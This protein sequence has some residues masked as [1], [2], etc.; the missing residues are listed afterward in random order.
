MAMLKQDL[1]RVLAGEKAAAIPEV[2]KTTASYLKVPKPKSKRAALLVGMAVA[3]LL[4]VLPLIYG[5]VNKPDQT[6]DIASDFRRHRNKAISANEMK[7]YVEAEREYLI[8]LQLAQ[9]AGDQEG[10]ARCYHGLYRSNYRRWVQTERDLS[11]TALWETATKHIKSAVATL[12]PMVLPDLKAR[13]FSNAKFRSNLSLLMVCYVDGFVIAQ[14]SGNDAEALR[15]GRKFVD[16][17]SQY[18]NFYSDR[19]R[20][21]GLHARVLDFIIR[22]DAELGQREDGLKYLRMYEQDVKN[23]LIG[24]AEQIPEYKALL[25]AS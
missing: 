10:I 24:G 15:M 8:A 2:Q 5:L 12:E 14:E 21:T 1:Q 13:N 16:L 11:K 20:G 22:K 4:C 18:S 23:G 17:F 3:G 25:N 19:N 7:R 9:R 6:Q